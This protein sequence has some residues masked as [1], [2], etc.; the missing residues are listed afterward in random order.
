MA[1]WNQSNMQSSCWQWGAK[2]KSTDQQWMPRILAP[3][4]MPEIDHRVSQ[5]F[6]GIVQRTDPLEAKQ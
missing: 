5:A 1:M 4:K 3:A 2:L 6:Q